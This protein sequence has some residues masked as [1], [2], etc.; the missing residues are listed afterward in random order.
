MILKGK[1]MT[2]RIEDAEKCKKTQD[3]SFVFTTLLSRDSNV[4]LRKM[5]FTISYKNAL[6]HKR[7]ALR[8]I[9]TYS[10]R[11]AARARAHRRSVKTSIRQ[12]D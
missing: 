11:L 12:R 9:G 3:K 4:V 10:A 7:T 8:V 6:S 1:R 5:C 2:Q